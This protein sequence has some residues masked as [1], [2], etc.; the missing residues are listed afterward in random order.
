[1]KKRLRRLTAL[2][3]IFTWVSSWL[4]IGTALAGSSEAQAALNAQQNLITDLIRVKDSADTAVLDAQSQLNSATIERQLALNTVSDKKSALDLAQSNYDSNLVQVPNIVPGIVADVYT[5]TPAG[6]PQRSSTAYTFCKTE[7]LGNINNSWGSGNIEGCGL[8]RIMIHYHGY[9]TYPVT[10]RVSFKANADDGFYATIGSTQ[11]VT[12]WYDKGCNSGSIHYFDF[13]ANVSYPID[14]WYYENGGGA[15]STLYHSSSQTNGAWQVVPASM[16]TQDPITYS[17]VELDPALLVVLQQAEVEYNDALLNLDNKNTAYN[18]AQSNYMD[19]LNNQAIIKAELDNAIKQIPILQEQLNQAILA[20]ATPVPTEIPTPEPTAIPTPVI[21]KEPTPT[22]TES[23]APT[24]TVEVTVSPVITEMPTPEPTEAPT[25]V[26]TAEPTPEIIITPTPTA[27]PTIAPTIEPSIEPVVTPIIVDTPRP[28]VSPTPEPIATIEPIFTTVP[29]PEVTISPI[30]LPTVEPT[31]KPTYVPED[32]PIIIPTDAP[33]IIPT[34]VP[35]IEPTIVPEL[36]ISTPEPTQMPI[37][38]E[39]P[40]VPESAPIVIT[41]PVETPT[42]ITTPDPAEAPISSAEPTSSPEPM[43]TNIIPEISSDGVI[44]SAGDAAIATGIFIKN[45]FTDP[46]EALKAIKAVGSSM[47]EEERAA[48]RK[49][50]VPAILVNNII[51]ALGG[52]I[53]SRSIRR[54][55]R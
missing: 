52:A 19:A 28:T 18:T 49:V 45:L 46:K 31:I 47:T 33:I 38:I 10:T 12:D 24:P 20:E 40:I 22:I 51:S 8:D 1:M 16:L 26:P 48:A 35:T 9:I 41:M 5:K 17:S 6:A 55:R 23:P 13:E 37:K 29:T 21:T 53:S 11:I 34:V 50:V 39:I 25:L 3:L 32:T 44:G 30:E 36:I 43:P 14:A 54:V 27:E 2:I 4:L 7:T 42:P 15:C